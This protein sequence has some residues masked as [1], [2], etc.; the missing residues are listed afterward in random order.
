M[1][2]DK[3]TGDTPLFAKWNISTYTITFN[4]NG[5]SSIKKSSAEY[6]TKISEP[7]APKRTGY[8][9]VGWYKDKELKNVWNFMTDKVTAN[10]TLYA[11][12]KK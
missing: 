11:K 8:K 3:V 12:W 9:F 1:K 10:T 4:T 5:G 7:I 2:S 6:N